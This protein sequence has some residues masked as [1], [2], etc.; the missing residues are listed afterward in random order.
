MTRKCISYGTIMEIVYA[1]INN[2]PV[3]SLITNGHDNHPWLK[4]HSK[5]IFTTFVGLEKNFRDF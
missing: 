4:Y 1:K 5:K 2:K 3:Y